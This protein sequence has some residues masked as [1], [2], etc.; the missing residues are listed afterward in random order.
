MRFIV[1]N[2]NGR[3]VVDQPIIA[4]LRAVLNN[5]PSLIVSYAAVLVPVAR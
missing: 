5:T 2:R 4:Y 1:L 3:I